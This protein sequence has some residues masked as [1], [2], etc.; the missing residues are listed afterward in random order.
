MIMRIQ[1][2]CLIAAINGKLTPNNYKLF[3][4]WL[5]GYDYVV[6]DDRFLSYALI[7]HMLIEAPP[8]LTPTYMFTLWIA[9]DILYHNASAETQQE[10]LR[11]TLGLNN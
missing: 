10:I 7:Q 1:T 4:E 8:I 2:A 6:P 5:G 3:A 9:S 11:W